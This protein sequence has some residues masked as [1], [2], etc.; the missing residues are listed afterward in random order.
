MKIYKNLKEKIYLLAKKY[1]KKA[2][3]DLPYFIKG[4]FWLSVGQFFST[5]KGFILSIVFAN[6]LSKEVFGEY[7]F[8]MAVLGIAGIF[9]LP[10][11]GI[12]VVQAVAKG[13]EGTYFKALKEVFKWS[14]LGS[15]FLLCFSIYEYFFGKF[16]LCLIFLILSSLFPFYSIS[17]F[18]PNF[19]NGKK[20]FDIL[21]KLSSFFNIISTILIIMMVL[22]TKSAFWIAITSILIQILVNC[23]FSIF[24]VKKFIEN[25][26][27]DKN[28]IEF[29]KKISYSRAFGGF[30]GKVDELII[31]YFLGFSDLAIFKIVTL[32]PDQFKIFMKLLNPMI[33]PKMVSSNISKKDLK[34]YFWKF[35]IVLVFLIAIYVLTAP[36]IFKIFYPKYYKYLWLSILY[37]LSFIAYLNILSSNYLIKEKSRYIIIIEYICNIFTIVSSFIFIYFYGL[38]GAIYSRMLI[39]LFSLL[40]TTYVFMRYCY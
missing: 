23:Y 34:T 21:V 1:S 25:Y 35:F 7:S 36:F 13:Y 30:A 10:G 2:G 12:A 8:I 20:R 16:D 11:M 3:L 39:R 14:W 9:A 31:S 40:L 6:F 27:V 32:I 19:F 17:G 18:Y 22:F 37:H 5:L 38:H 15:L 28:D 26:G 24:Y 29:G 33:L 4:G